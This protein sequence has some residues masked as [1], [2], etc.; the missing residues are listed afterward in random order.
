MSAS[1][2]DFIVIDHRNEILSGSA[3][4]LARR[5]CARRYSA[6]ADGLILIEKSQAADFRVR[7][8]N[9][10]GNEFNTCGN[11]GRCAARFA[12]LHALAPSDMTIET[13]IGVI[14][15]HITGNAVK[16][17]FVSPAEI[18]LNVPFE[19]DGQTRSGHLVRLGEPHFI[20]AETNIGRIPFVPIARRIR[21]HEIFG[22]D[23][24][25]VHFIEPLS[26]N[27]LMI[28]SF[29]RGI[30]DETLACGSGCI[31]ASVSTFTGKQTDPPITI[32]PQSGI[33]LTVHFQPGNNFQD[34][35]LEGDARLLYRGELTSEAR[36]W[37]VPIPGYHNRFRF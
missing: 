9:P 33:P 2:N 3:G 23:G 31:A 27:R 30:E 14:D 22:T 36:E 24:S 6:G 17:K 10:N 8:Y 15:A 5:I 29:E 11:G 4:D 7:F 19:F 1:A 21:H 25:N 35:Y 26:R 12:F 34:L 16:L 13:N 28:R 37:K 20:V 18:R 32:E